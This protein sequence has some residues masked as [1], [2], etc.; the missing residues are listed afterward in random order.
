M[1]R[2]L[3]H[4][5]AV[6]YNEHMLELE[7]GMDAISEDEIGQPSKRHKAAVRS[8]DVAMVDTAEPASSS[9]AGFRYKTERELLAALN[10]AWHPS[11][12]CL[13]L[14]ACA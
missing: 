5:K 1:G 4:R 12:Q 7:N 9:S 13:T 2:A 14:Q 10:Q 3:R 8:A 6:T 11:R